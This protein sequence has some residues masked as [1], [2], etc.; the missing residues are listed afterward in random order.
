M[1]LRACHK[2]R[3]PELLCMAHPTWKAATHEDHPKKAALQMLFM[4]SNLHRETSV[5]LQGHSHDI[6]YTNPYINAFKHLFNHRHVPFYRYP[7]MRM[8]EVIVIKDVPY[9]KSLYYKYLK[10]STF[11][12]PLFLSISLNQLLIDIRADQRYGLFL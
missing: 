9:R 7:L 6:I 11:S 4:R 2:T 10:F 3:P 12:S 1:W 5:T 8:I